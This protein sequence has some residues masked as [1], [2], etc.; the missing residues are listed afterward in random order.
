MSS[1]KKR[2][3]TEWLKREAKRRKEKEA[4]EKLQRFS[5][6]GDIEVMAAALGIRLQ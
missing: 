6:C 3:H 1:K 5:N 2:R 4:R